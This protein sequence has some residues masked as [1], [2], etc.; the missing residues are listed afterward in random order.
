VRRDIKPAK[1]RVTAEQRAKILDF[2][3]AKAVTPFHTKAIAGSEDSY[4]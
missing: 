1:I 2:G 4:P 3:L